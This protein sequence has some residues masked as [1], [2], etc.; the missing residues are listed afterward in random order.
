MA[1]LEKY[2]SPIDQDVREFLVKK[3]GSDG[4]RVRMRAQ[5]TFR[6]LLDHSNNM[7]QQYINSVMWK[8]VDHIDTDDL[9]QEMALV[10]KNLFYAYEIDRGFLFESLL[11]RSLVN[12][13]HGLSYRFKLHRPDRIRTVSVHTT[14]KQTGEDTSYENYFFKI[15]EDKASPE[16]T[17]FELRENLS[18]LQDQLKKAAV[19]R[20]DQIHVRKAEALLNLLGMGYSQWEVA[21]MLEDLRANSPKPETSILESEYVE[22]IETGYKFKIF[23]KNSGKKYYEITHDGRLSL[24]KGRFIIPIMAL[25][26]YNMCSVENNKE[27]LEELEILRDVLSVGELL[28]RTRRRLECLR[29]NLFTDIPETSAIDKP[30]PKEVPEEL[31][32]FNVLKLV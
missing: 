27:A 8:F 18:T 26:P 6:N 1:V 29:D 22:H 4:R 25:R 30:P 13:G 16:K 23:D 28:C 21:Q 14:D 31:F 17:D 20:V 10:V 19:S 24:Q 32:T 2:A 3:V 15:D 5:M 9:Y 11:Q 7:I 12:R